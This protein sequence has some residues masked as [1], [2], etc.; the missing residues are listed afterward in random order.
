MPSLRCSATVLSALG[1]G[2]R[3][4]RRGHWERDSGDGSSDDVTIT[5]LEAIDDDHVELTPRANISLSPGEDDAA[6][7]NNLQEREENPS[8]PFRSAY[9]AREDPPVVV[10]PVQ[11]HPELARRCGADEA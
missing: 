1:R 10:S 3:R 8:S 4:Y 7:N 9:G 2:A 11:E 5:T 6:T